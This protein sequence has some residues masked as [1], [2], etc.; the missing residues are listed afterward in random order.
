MDVI[1]VILVIRA[2]VG[3]E[4]C[5]LA[6]EVLKEKDLPEDHLRGDVL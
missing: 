3:T 1:T 5:Q 4:F 2:E 6:A